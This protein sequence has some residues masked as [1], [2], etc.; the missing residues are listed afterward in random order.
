MQ[1]SD[2]SDEGDSVLGARD[3]AI[4][5]DDQDGYPQDWCDTKRATDTSTLAAIDML[6]NP[7]AFTKVKWL[8][9]HAPQYA[10]LPHPVPSTGKWDTRSA[11]MEAKLADSMQYFMAG[12]E[13][14]DKDGVVKGFA[15]VRSVF[16]DIRQDRRHQSLRGVRDR[17]AVLSPRRDDD[18]AQ[19]LSRDE[20]KR[21]QKQ[22]ALKD[23][24]AA[25]TK[26]A[27][28]F[29]YGRTKDRGKGSNS[30]KG[31]QSHGGYSRG[32]GDHRSRSQGRKGGGGDPK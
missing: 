11:N 18:R 8:R 12:I 32:K 23:A 10:G 17:R 31:S 6:S 1:R 22:R 16:E 14:A 19:L 21:A 5:T 2:G 26:S 3:S 25:A 30:G 7:P 28:N 27:S 4:D 15:L 20:Q 9:E 29:R 13:G 24:A